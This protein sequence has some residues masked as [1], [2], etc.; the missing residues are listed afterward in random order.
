MLFCRCAGG[1][2]E[3]TRVLLCGRL[4][5][6]KEGIGREGAKEREAPRLLHAALPPA[7]LLL[8]LLLPAGSPG[9]VG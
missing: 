5:V 6:K 8:L 9:D 1:G 2:G 4:P 3:G 7:S